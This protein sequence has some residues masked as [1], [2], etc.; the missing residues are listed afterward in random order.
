MRCNDL[1]LGLLAILIGTIVYIHSQSF[2]PMTDGHPGPGLFPSVLSGLFILAGIVLCVQGAKSRAPLFSRLPDLDGRGFANICVALL[3]IVF[4]IYASAP[5]G[6]LITSFACM[7]V[8]M[9]TL[10]ARAVVA[11]PVAAGMTLFI[12]LVFHKVLLVPLP[13]G[14]LY[15]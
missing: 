11:L 2:P 9:L 3:A 15:F 13:R 10:K 1:V 8:L 14:L 6:F 12:Y 4:F 5:L 7:L